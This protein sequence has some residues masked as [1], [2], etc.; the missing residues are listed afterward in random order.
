MTLGTSDAS[1]KE[2][3]CLQ[4]CFNGEGNGPFESGCET[5]DF[6]GDLD[7][8]LRDFASFERLFSP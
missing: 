2:L 8:D 3:T 7:I 1:S 5:L 4:N 6:D